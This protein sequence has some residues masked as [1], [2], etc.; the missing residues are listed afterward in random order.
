M[1][2]PVQT[3]VRPAQPA[4]QLIGALP[5]SLLLL[6]EMTHR[7]SNEYALAIS[8]ISLA[9]ARSSNA[10]AKAAL[11]EA[12]ARLRDFAEAHRALQAP[13]AAG[14]MDLSAYLQRLCGALVRAS[15]AERG[16]RLTFVDQP[17]ELAADRCWRVGLIVSELITNAVRH[18]LGGRAGEIVVAVMVKD[19][20]EVHCRVTDNGGSDDDAPRLGRGSHIV[21]ALAA[22][23]GG[24][25]ER[26]FTAS[27]T[28]VLL[29][30]P[31]RADA[32]PSPAYGLA[33][34]G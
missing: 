15:L 6:A 21:D 7:V 8:S 26:Q 5:Q 31:Q 13:M 25:V 14:A 20:G 33:L 18:G 12:A 34:G 23:L 2:P 28:T 19:S 22:E 10:E 4:P 17:V 30:F 1:T 24:V 27:G 11:A 9:A 32:G 3:S 29:L 16:I